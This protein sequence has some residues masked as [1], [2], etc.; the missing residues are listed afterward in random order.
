V[1]LTKLDRAAV[2]RSF[3][4]AA[5][6]Y[7]AAAA[8]QREVA[9][10][11]FERLEHFAPE[12][13]PGPQRVL[14]L[15]CGTGQGSAALADRFPAASVIALDWSRG[16][17]SRWRQVMGPERRSCFAVNADMHRL[18]L[19]SRSVDLVFCSLALQWSMEESAV[20]DE[21]RRILRP[22]GLFLFSSFGP[23]TLEELRAAWA[24][25]DDRPHVNRFADMH[26]L[27]DALVRAGY[28]DPVVD[29]EHL[30][31]TYSDPLAVMRELKALG[32][33]NSALKRR[34]GLT[35]RAALRCVLDAYEQYRDD[36]RYP[37]TYEVIYGVARG[38][39]EGQ[40]VRSD[41]GEIA[42]FS[43]D[44]LRTRR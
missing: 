24:L 20:F 42:T 35:G 39:G 8:L 32:A 26:D 1:T 33:H 36:G 6:S 15:G 40:P 28:R 12:L 27:G 44:S 13:E 2:R 9:A 19:A 4:R 7:D 11:L 22:G 14:D 30:R 41:D 38:P 3:D 23:D 25:V 29:S 21:V 18:P 34:P 5:N 43:V 16:M 10:R 17:L 31:L 37:A